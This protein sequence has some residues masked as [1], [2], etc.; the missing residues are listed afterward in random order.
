MFLCWNETNCRPE[1]FCKKIVLFLYYIDMVFILILTV[2]YS[3]E[4]ATGGVL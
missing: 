4:A 3:S 1:V 2:S